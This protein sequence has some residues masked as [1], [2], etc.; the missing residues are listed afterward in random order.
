MGVTCFI[1]SPLNI[2]EYSKG[3]VSTLSF[4]LCKRDQIHDCVHG[5]T[6]SAEP[7]HVIGQPP[8]IFNPPLKPDMYNFLHC[9][10]EAA[11]E[12]DWTK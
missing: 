6:P 1:K 10:T 3:N 11:C 8:G 2:E 12:A 9:F 7:H 4:V 5:A